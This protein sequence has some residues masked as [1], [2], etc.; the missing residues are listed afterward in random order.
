[1]RATF[2]RK[3][4]REGVFA[5]VRS[6]LKW[7][8]ANPQAARYIYAAASQTELLAHW[9]HE[10]VGFKQALVSPF[11]TWFQG[12]IDSGAIVALPPALME[13]VVIGP[14]AEFARRWLSGGPGLEMR[15]ATKAL[16]EA[17]WRAIAR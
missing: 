10:L 3:S 13:V 1:M 12:H 14:P 8:E 9:R 2:R 17:V 16:P 15:A 7:V 11:V 5:L 6:Y 4:A